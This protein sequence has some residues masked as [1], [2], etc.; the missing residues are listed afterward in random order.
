MLYTN[1]SPIESL[2]AGCRSTNHCRVSVPMAREDEGGITTAPPPIIR[3]EIV[4]R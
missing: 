2:R 4:G 3:N 1:P